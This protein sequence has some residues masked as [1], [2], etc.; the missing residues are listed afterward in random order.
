MNKQ[1]KI[2]LLTLASLVCLSACGA[3]KDDKEN[4]ST[5]N[6][7]ETYVTIDQDALT[8]TLGD[9]Q[10]LTAV[11]SAEE[12][13]EFVWESSNPSVASVNEFGMVT[14]NGVGTTNISAKYGEKTDS[15]TVTVSLGTYA[16][17]LSSNIGDEKTLQL[18][19][20]DE[21]DFGYKIAFR[22]QEYL[23]GTFNYEVAD[24]TIGKVENG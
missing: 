23:D 17:T 16:P 9:S 18:T 13:A 7:V 21:I 8:L 5:S 10:L 15:C 22:G 3:C 14:T 4:S 6:P 12:W 11:Y 1:L 2:I 19:T 24:E 20:G